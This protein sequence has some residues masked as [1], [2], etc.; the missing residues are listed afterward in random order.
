MG[1]EAAGLGSVTVNFDINALN[2]KLDEI[3]GALSGD[4]KTLVKQ[5]AMQL[6]ANTNFDMSD[7]S[8]IQIARACIDRAIIIVNELKNQK[9]I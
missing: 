2:S 3:I 1:E 4:E 8:P 7:K 9:I 5:C 6:Y